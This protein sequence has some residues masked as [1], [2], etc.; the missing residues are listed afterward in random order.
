MTDP[1]S[2]EFSWAEAERRTFDLLLEAAGSTEN[3]DGFLGA[4]PGIANAWHVEPLPIGE[5]QFSL[6]AP[7]C[8]AIYV[9][10]MATGVFRRRDAAQTLAM[11]WLKALPVERDEASNIACLRVRSI[12]GP[13]RI[14]LNLANEKAPVACWQINVVFDLAFAT[15]GKSL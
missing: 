8:P 9:Q 11:R 13:E 5:S 6:L 15:G 3:R 10:I 1:T 7:D 4:S 14:V 12:Q 2:F